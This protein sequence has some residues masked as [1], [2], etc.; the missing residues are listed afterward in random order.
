[1]KPTFKQ[2]LIETAGEDRSLV[3]ISKIISEYLEDKKSYFR[4][5]IKKSIYD[6]KYT[7]IGSIEKLIYRVSPSNSS[8]ILSNLPDNFGSVKLSL[9]EL[10]DTD[11]S[12]EGQWAPDYNTIYLHTDYI[13]SNPVD[14]YK[15]R[16]YLMHE[17]RHALDDHKKKGEPN[18]YVNARAS[19]VDS[20]DKSEDFIK[21]QNSPSEI[22]ARYGQAIAS[23]DSQLDSAFWKEGVYDSKSIY[24]LVLSKF[25]KY[26]IAY[27]FPEKTESKEYKRLVRRAVDYIQQRLD[28]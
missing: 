27:L 11:G 22:N 18:K 6:N 15:L 3:M 19:N 14:T 12:Y 20:I 16:T 28:N 23:I 24:A 5:K 9:K 10:K 7:S 4:S 21:Y 13:I 2:Y 17:L 26:H 1:M 25:K 8:N